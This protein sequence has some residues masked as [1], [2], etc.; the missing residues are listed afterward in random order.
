MLTDLSEA[1]EARRNV[2]AAYDAGD[3]TAAADRLLVQQCVF[4]DD[5]GCQKHYEIVVRN[6]DYFTDLMAAV[7]RQ[8]IVD[9]RE[10]MLTV[11][12]THPLARAVLQNDET[13]LLLVLRAVFERGV[14]DFGQGDDGEIETTSDDVLDRYEPMSGRARPTWQRAYEMLRSYDRR[15]FVRVSEPENGESNCQIVIRP[16]IRHVTGDDWMT[17]LEEWLAAERG[18]VSPALPM[19]DDQ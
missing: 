3:F 9:E 12:P 13:I 2:G 4:R 14:S 7:G 19:G 18:D 11:V 17:R 15:R 8:L 10:R 6:V 1:L 16:S 5:W